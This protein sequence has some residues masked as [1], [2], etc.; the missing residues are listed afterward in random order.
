[1]GWCGCLTLKIYLS[2]KETYG[3]DRFLIYFFYKILNFKGQHRSLEKES[4]ELVA[5]ETQEKNDQAEDGG[6]NL[7][8]AR[9][10]DEPGFQKVEPV[11]FTTEK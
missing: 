2:V 8:Q 5:S 4:W 11:F 6:V 10:R 7:S 9:K 3:Q 1:M